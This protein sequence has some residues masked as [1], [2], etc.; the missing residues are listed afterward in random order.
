VSP[1]IDQ[2]SLDLISHS[3]EQT[4]RLGSYLGALAVAGDVFCLRGD[5]GVGKTCFIQGI[6]AGMG[7]H[8]PINSPS[9]TLVNEYIVPGSGLRLFHIDLY[10]LADAIEEARAIGLD[11]YLYGNGVCAIEWSERAWELM[12][13]Q[14]LTIE[15]RHI[16][17]YK[18]GLLLRAE[19]TR[20]EE[21]LLAFRKKAFGN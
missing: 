6:G 16:D 19:G 4:R 15:M 17:A 3:P 9:F 13:A 5:L 20:H 12:P 2:H 14:R 11:E 8:E 21:L 10:R 7:V 1:I 18:R